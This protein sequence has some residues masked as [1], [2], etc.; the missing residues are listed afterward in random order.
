MTFQV[1]LEPYEPCKFIK[2]LYFQKLSE[3][4]VF[5]SRND[6]FFTN[7]SL[8]NSR[9]TKNLDFVLGINP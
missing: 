4:T 3:L 6:Y 9:E 2:K 1:F 5:I 8:S 7:C